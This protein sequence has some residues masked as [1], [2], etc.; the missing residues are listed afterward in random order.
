MA[1]GFSQGSG[2]VEQITPLEGT[3]TLSEM[4]L[5][6]APVFVGAGANDLSATVNAYVGTDETFTIEIDDDSGSPNTFRWSLDGGSTWE[7]EDVEITGAVQEL[8]D[9]FYVRFAS[10]VGHVVGDVWTVDVQILGD[11]FTITDA[12]GTAVLEV[13]Y[14][15]IGFFGATPIAPPA[16]AADPTAAQISTV[17]QTYGLTVLP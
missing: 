4:L 15:G 16:L 6:E 2:L 1:G 10:L 17:L 12:S 5:V 3:L 11:G 13:T 9:G 8:Q 7:V 14:E